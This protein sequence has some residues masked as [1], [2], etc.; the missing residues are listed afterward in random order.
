MNSIESLIVGDNQVYDKEEIRK[1]IDDHFKDVFGKSRSERLTFSDHPWEDFLDLC[2]L[3]TD[4]SKEKNQKSSVGFGIRKSIRPRQ[5][6]NTILQN[7]LESS[8]E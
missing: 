6:S 1:C 7:P 2:I 3:E 5:L 4:F 8:K